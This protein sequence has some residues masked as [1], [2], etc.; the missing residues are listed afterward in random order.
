MNETTA[1]GKVTIVD[2]T[3]LIEQLGAVQHEQARILHEL[4]TRLRAL[5][6]REAQEVQVRQ[7]ATRVQ[8]APTWTHW[9]FWLSLPLAAL[10]IFLALWVLARW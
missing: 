9:P 7:E 3:G 10:T 1:K 5:E 4:E 6:L 2:I 8:P